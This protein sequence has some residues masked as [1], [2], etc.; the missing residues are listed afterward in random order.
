MLTALT[1]VATIPVFWIEE[2]DGFAPDMMT[3]DDEE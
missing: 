3:D 2:T 1:V